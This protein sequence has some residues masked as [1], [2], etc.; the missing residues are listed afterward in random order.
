MGNSINVANARVYS[1]EYRYPVIMQLANNF[2]VQAIAM[3]K[4]VGYMVGAGKAMLGKK[5][6]Y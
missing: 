4:A 2:W 6:R 5:F 1:K 3:Y